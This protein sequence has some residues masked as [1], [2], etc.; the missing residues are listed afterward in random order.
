MTALHRKVDKIKSYINY[1]LYEKQ[2][3]WYMHVY[4]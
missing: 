1:M 2:E 3:I 4:Q